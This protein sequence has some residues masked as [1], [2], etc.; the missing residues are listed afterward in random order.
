MFL[1]KN[2]DDSRKIKITAKSDNKLMPG[3]DS[4]SETPKSCQLVKTILKSEKNNDEN[5]Q[6]P[7]SLT[8]S[9]NSL[10]AGMNNIIDKIVV[11]EKTKIRRLTVKR[12]FSIS[13]R[14]IIFS[15][16]SLGGST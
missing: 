13:K 1:T 10:N 11:K 5:C 16:R 4:K 3:K 12:L 7:D 15:K 2:L 8:L 6:K 9:C 14:D